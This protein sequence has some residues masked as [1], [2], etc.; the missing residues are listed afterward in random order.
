MKNTWKGIKN[1][2][3]LKTVS[4]SS[5]SSIYYNNKTVTSPFRM[6]N[7]FNNYF[8]NIV[9]NMQSSIKYS[10]KEFHEFFR[11]LNT[12]SFFLSPTDKNEIISIISTLD[13]QKVSR[14]NSI[15]IK[16]LKL[17]KNDIPDQ[18]P[19][20]FNLSFTWDSFPTSLKTSKV[21]PIY[22]KNSKHKCSS[23]R[24]ISLLSNIDKIFERIL[25]NYLYKFFEENKLICNPQFGFRQNH[26][27][28]HTLIHL[29]GKICEQ[30]DSG[31]FGCG[32]LLIFRKLLILLITQFLPKS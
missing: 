30:L 11:P 23:Y 1:L 13:S 12:N 24:P 8:S 9:L 32:F 4:H 10:V 3:S 22:K 29:T 14:P 28:T 31:K 2:I 25:Y 5:P 17:M 6:A 27:T 15:P 18:L 26:S 19:V 20:L 7:P 16:T 21:T